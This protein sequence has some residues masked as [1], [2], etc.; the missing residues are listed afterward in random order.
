MLK[1]LGPNAHV[2][3]TVVKKE[4]TIQYLT[5]H[6]DFEIVFILQKKLNSVL[7]SLLSLEFS[8]T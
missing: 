5:V 2:G 3:R 8:R 6:L 1:L 7:H 4:I